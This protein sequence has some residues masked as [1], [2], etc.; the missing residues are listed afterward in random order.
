MIARIAY[1][2][3][4][5]ILAVVTIGLQSDRQAAL[6]P[7]F[8]QITPDPFRAFAQ[9]TLTTSTLKSDDANAAVAEARTLVARR[10]FP[11]ESL[12]S[13]AQAQLLGG[14]TE[15]AL[16][17]LQ[18]AAQRGWRD[19]ATQDA[20]MRLA[21]AARDEEQA[22]RRFLALLV[23]DGA[24][25]DT[26]RE[27][28]PHLFDEDDRVAVQTS[29]KI[30]AASERWS[31]RFIQRGSRVIHPSP[32]ATILIDAAAQG[33]DFECGAI[34]QAARSLG[35]ND[36]SAAARVSTIACTRRDH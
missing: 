19:R 8:V 11:A 4:L 13:L 17:S 2:A 26:L 12:R 5:V 23:L 30:L 15:E 32:F 24:S 3:M 28:A 1:I 6:D 25:E 21:M 22:T 16:G 35:S 31:N 10:P 18:L 20:M 34:E 33:A 14:N 9:M 36:R 27:I 29:S 7:R